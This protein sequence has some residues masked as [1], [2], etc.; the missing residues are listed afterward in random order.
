MSSQPTVVPTPDRRRWRRGLQVAL[1]VALGLGLASPAWSASP[2]WQPIS[3]FSPA[4][5]QTTLEYTY[6]CPTAF[7]IASSGGFETNSIGQASDTVLTAN[8]PRFDEGTATA[9]KAWAWHFFW[10]NGAPAG[11]TI[12]FSVY[13]KKS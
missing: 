3:E 1:P 7:P 12:Q 2:G 13:C 10:P 8:G 4:T 6:P 11:I 9:F 5:G